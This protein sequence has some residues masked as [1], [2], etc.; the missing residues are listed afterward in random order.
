M[1]FL[2]ALVPGQVSL[3]AIWCSFGRA[4]AV[5]R[6]LSAWAAALFGAVLLGRDGLA[7]HVAVLALQFATSFSLASMFRFSGAAIGRADGAPS[8]SR[9]GPYSLAALLGLLTVWSIAAGLLREQGIFS[10][11]LTRLLTGLSCLTLGVVVVALARREDVAMVAALAVVFVA[12]AVVLIGTDDRMLVEISLVQCAVAFAVGWVI[13]C[14]GWRVYWRPSS[15]GRAR[16][17]QGRGAT[18]VV[19]VES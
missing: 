7:V 4:P 18:V 3:V 10:L 8:G 9:V 2:L 12:V 1:T 19:A 5:V 13:R 17:R 16:A 6:A 14:G 15:R 11:D